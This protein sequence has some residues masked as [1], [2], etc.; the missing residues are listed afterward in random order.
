MT[1]SATASRG[2]ISRVLPSASCRVIS[3]SSLLIPAIHYQYA[4]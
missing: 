2:E 3:P 4:D 1:P